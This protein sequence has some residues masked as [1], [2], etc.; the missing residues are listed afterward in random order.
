MTRYE[1]E[2]VCQCNV[3]YFIK[4]YLDSDYDKDLSRYMDHATKIWIADNRGWMGFYEDY[5]N[6]KHW[7]EKRLFTKFYHVLRK[8]SY[9]LVHK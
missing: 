1:F 2:N 4:T 8:N 5:K 7:L 6:D 3:D 9:T